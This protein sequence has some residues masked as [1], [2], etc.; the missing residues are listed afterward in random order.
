MKKTRLVDIAAAAGVG[1][2][3]VE[4]VLNERGKIG[5]AHV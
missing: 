3:T 1:I 2:A 5:R 4:R